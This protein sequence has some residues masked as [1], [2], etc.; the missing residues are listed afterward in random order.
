MVSI[1]DGEPFVLN[2]NSLYP[3]AGIST[4]DS[5]NEGLSI[6]MAR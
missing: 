3:A 1:S 2:A 5:I 6:K 4:S